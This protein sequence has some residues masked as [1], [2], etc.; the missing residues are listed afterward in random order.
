M[1]EDLRNSRTRGADIYGQYLSAA[2]APLGHNIA[3]SNHT[4]NQYSP[5]LVIAQNNGQAAFLALWEDDEVNR[6]RLDLRG[7]WLTAG[8]K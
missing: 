8:G 4:S 5:A 7:V 3:L 1:W 6:T 2:G